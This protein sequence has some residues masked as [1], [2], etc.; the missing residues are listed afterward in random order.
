MMIGQGRYQWVDLEG[1]LQS[2]TH[3]DDLPEKMDRII[4][5]NPEIPDE[6]HTEE[7]H[8]AYAT[9]VPKLQEAMSRCQR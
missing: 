3:W 7:Q 4:E 8:E 9:F 6:P 1:K 2:G 5:F